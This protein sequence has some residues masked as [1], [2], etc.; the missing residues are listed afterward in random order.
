MGKTDPKRG[1]GGPAVMIMIGLKPG[2]DDPD[3]MMGKSKAPSFGAAK[4]KTP[5][6]RQSNSGKVPSFGGKTRRTWTGS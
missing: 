1:L 4:P 6:A 5:P 3:D 2:K